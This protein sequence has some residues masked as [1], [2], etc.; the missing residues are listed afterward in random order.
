MRVRMFGIALIIA[1]CAAACGGGS[2]SETAKPVS[3][4]APP[5]AWALKVEPLELPVGMRSNAPQ[6]TVSSRGVLLSWIEPADKTAS[7]KFAERVPSG[8]SEATQVASGSNWFLSYADM[9][10][11]MRLR[12]GTLVSNWYLTTNILVEGYDI[13]L[14]YSRDEGK[15]WSKPQK[16]NRDKTKTQ[17]GF[18]SMFE[19]PNGGLGL[20]WLD[21][22]DQENNTTDPEGGSIALYAATFDAAF[23]PTG[24]T[25]VNAR[26]CECCST[27]AAVTDQGVITAF[28]DRSEK[29]IRDIAVTRL[30]NGK[31]SDAKTVH[32]DKWEIDSCPVNGPAIS[33]RGTQVAVAW[34]SAKDNK[35][36]SFA[37][38]SSD[39]GRTWG[40]PIALED[41]TSRGYVDIELLDD[42]SAVAAWVEFEGGRSQFKVRRVESSGARSSSITIANGEAGVV[43]YPRIA[44][45]GGELVF[46]WTEGK[47]EEAQHIKGAVA[48]VP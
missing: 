44:R 3:T 9:P 43:G 11:V 2:S 10:T 1:V 35:G 14:A 34:F 5:P 28:R 19:P 21:A 26:V 6:M 37:A 13:L 38:F 22:R 30:E 42:G 47:D 32:D 36:R 48:R 4:A 39:A 24:E 45:N 7:L 16:P 41:Q 33:A 46:A 27:A 18:V 25:M 12:D 20:V 8:W 29:E 40:Q 31:W 23:K 17:H 15:T